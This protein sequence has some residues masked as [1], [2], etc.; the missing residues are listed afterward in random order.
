M[1]QRERF[2][3]SPTSYIHGYRDS[4]GRIAS[5]NYHVFSY[6]ELTQW[7]LNELIERFGLI[8][9]NVIGSIGV[10]ELKVNMKSLSMLNKSFLIGIF[11]CVGLLS[12]LVAIGQSP[13]PAPTGLTA[14]AVSP[15]HVN[16]SWTASTGSVAGYYVLRNG[17]QVG[18]P[19]STGWSTATGTPTAYSDVDLSPSTVYTYTVEAYASGNVVSSPSAAVTTTTWP[20][21]TIPSAPYIQPF[22][23]CVT[24]YYVSKTGSD[25]NNGSSGSPWYSISTAINF[26]T[27][28][29]GTLGGVCVNVGPGTYTESVY[30]D[31]LSGSADTPTGYFVLRSTTP[32][33]ATIELPPGSVDYTQGIWFLNASYFVV[34]GFVLAGNNAA[35]DIDGT[36]VST[37]GSSTTQCTS[38]HIRIYNN[39][40]YGWGGGG[41]GT[42]MEDYFDV[43]GNVVYN[44]S[45]TSIWGTSAL[46]AYE[47][48]ALDTGT[49][50]ASTMDSASVQYHQIFRYN[51]AYNNAEVNIGANTHYDGNGIS[52]DT[53][54]PNGSDYN[55]YAQQ[56]LIDSNLSFDNGG[57]GIVEGGYGASYLTVRNNT[58]FNNYIDAQNPSTGHGDISL[59][60][61]VSSHDNIIV[62]NIGVNDPNAEPDNYALIDVGVGS[63]A[64]ENINE[65]WDN[66]LSFDGTPGQASIYVSNTT[67]TITAANGNLLGTNP[68]FANYLSGNYAPQSTSP[69]I[70]AGTTAY[71]VAAID[72]AGNPRTT[73]GAVDIGAYQY[74]SSAAPVRPTSAIVLNAPAT[75]LAGTPVNV[76]L[77]LLSNGN[78]TPTGNVSILAAEGSGTP[79]QLAQ[80]S[81]A[82]ALITAYAAGGT[83]TTAAVTF[84]Q[85]GTYTLTASYA[86]DTN[87]AAGTSPSYTVIVA[88]LP[89]VATPTFSPVAGTYTSAQSVTISDT[90][91]N[92]TIYYTTDGSTPSSTSTQYSGAISVGSSETIN[93]IA[94]ASGDSDSD[95]ATAAYTINLPPTFT[96]SISPSSMSIASGQNGS[97]T[98][99][100]TPQNGFAAQTSFACTG[101]PTNASCSFSPSTVT[102]SGSA[103]T[104]TLTVSESASAGNVRPG[105]TLPF[106]AAGIALSGILFCFVG[107]RKRHHM[108]ALLTLAI[109]ALGLSLL[110]GCGGG[111]GSSTPP[112]VTAT[113]TVTAT[114]GSLQQT[115]TFTLTVN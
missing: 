36:G 63:A 13:L 25:T 104:T 30:A 6:R 59:A 27:A 8:A 44:N 45:N 11:G 24:N 69:V 60:G 87:F 80:A 65:K 64:D 105:T 12:Q 2:V 43:E 50:S 74:S 47:P 52:L 99:T 106:P 101:Q 66:N 108:R 34:D 37:A 96:I 102:P 82:N 23:T 22:Y 58:A 94:T 113:V 16:L 32:H 68:L 111:S 38:H 57:G 72:L 98:V 51:V 83:G 17:V 81:A 35:P 93:A 9:V 39:I 79:Q 103:I 86:G 42:Q 62:N 88:A 71:G 41:I 89:Q 26:L 90:T 114:A 7:Y 18:A 55:G 97:A 76:Q 70:G 61:F 20:A 1:R 78:G 10:I 40:A 31:T 54:N 19:T 109:V 29:G 3:H 49:W 4:D 115:T 73:S 107:W 46:G 92:A 28:Q 21:I 67:A 85:A 33:G 100:I 84:A 53:L 112:P 75:A 110:S 95:V 56:T 15:D 48:V 14:I 91:Q 77:F 5:A